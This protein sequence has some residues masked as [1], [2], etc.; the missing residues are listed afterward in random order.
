[1][2]EIWKPVVGYEGI[3][4][5]SSE[6]RVKSLSRKKYCGHPGAVQITKEKICGM[7]KDR[8]GYIKINLSKDN[9]RKKV[10]LHRIVALAFVENPKCKKEVNH[11][12]GNKENNLPENLEWST[13]SENMLHAFNE[14]LKKAKKGESNITSKLKEKEVLEIRALRKEGVKLIDIA[15]I[16]N[17]T[18]ANV[19]SIVN[20]KTWK[21]VGIE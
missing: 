3:Y 10:S 14:N 13:R 11:I 18:I 16:Y 17:V 1:M 15:K 4:E 20:F 5:V 7:S 12:D 8:L 2:M 6:G 9:K 21:D 19:S